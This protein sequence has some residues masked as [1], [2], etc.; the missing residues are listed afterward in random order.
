M[1]L[2][3]D[4]RISPDGSRIAYVQA[5]M[6]RESLRVSPLDLDSACRGRRAAPSSPPAPNDQLAALVA[7]W[8]DAGLRAQPAQRR[9]AE[10]TPSERDA[11]AGQPQ[12]WVLSARWRRADPTDLQRYG[13]GSPIWSP[14]GTTIALHRRGP[15]SQ[16][17]QRLTTRHYRDKT[18]AARAHHRPTLVPAAMGSRLHL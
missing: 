8:P 2:V 14:D 5:E 7:G 18:S 13:A 15:A 12:I 6:D 1:R 9:E 16:T 3:E 4:V 17:I 11:G 10:A